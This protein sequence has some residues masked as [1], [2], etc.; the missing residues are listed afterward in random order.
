MTQL[1]SYENKQF[2]SINP[3]IRT[4][5]T[6][7]A[8]NSD[9]KY[10]THQSF[11]TSDPTKYKPTSYYTSYAESRPNIDYSNYLYSE[12]VNLK[13]EPNFNSYENYTNY[14]TP[15]KVPS[16]KIEILDDNDL[17]EKTAQLIN[18][19]HK[20]KLLK[21]QREQTQNHVAP[22]IQT[23]TTP[24]TDY[25][26]KLKH[27]QEQVENL[28]NELKQKQLE[29]EQLQ[30]Q[31]QYH[32]NQTNFY[33]SNPILESNRQNLRCQQEEIR[34]DLEQKINQIN[35]HQQQ[36]QQK[37]IVA[38][39]QVFFPRSISYE[40]NK[41]Y[42]I[43]E[44]HLT[45]TQKYRSS[46]NAPGLTKNYT[47]NYEIN[48]MSRAEQFYQ[49]KDQE[50]SM[51]YQKLMDSLIKKSESRNNLKEISV[52]QPM[53][54]KIYDKIEN[55][56][57]SAKT[58]KVKDQ[59]H[60]FLYPSK[61]EKSLEL[62][63][64]DDRNYMFEK[65]LREIQMKRR[66]EDEKL[67]EARREQELR[68]KEILEQKLREKEQVEIELREQQLKEKIRREQE[69][70]EKE[71]LE[72][73]LREKEIIE[74][75]LIEQRVKEKI[76]LEQEA[77][78]R[79]ILEKKLKEQELK[80]KELSEAQ[81]RE[82]EILERQLREKELIEKELRENQLREHEEKEILAK[83]LR[84][85]EL[86][87]QRKKEAQKL[88]EKLKKEKKMQK[89]KS[90]EN[91][92]QINIEDFKRLQFA[93]EEINENGIFFDVHK[94]R[95]D[96]DVPHL[97]EDEIEIKD[98]NDRLPKTYSNEFNVRRKY[99]NL[100]EEEYAQSDKTE[101]GYN[102]K[103]DDLDENFESLVQE[104]KSNGNGSIS[105]RLSSLVSSNVEVILEEEE[106]EAEREYREM[107][108][109]SKSNTFNNFGHTRTKVI[110]NGYSSEGHE[111]YDD[112]DDVS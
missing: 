37:P 91:K 10:F 79:E 18:K 15:K 14:N 11:Y 3:P 30:K 89:F 74:K 26:D 71:L 102:N 31:I 28:Q 35:K 33:S 51:E 29:Q 66:L 23:T 64:N 78:E 7:S 36:Q 22:I 32:L 67:M 16:P 20:L 19:Q 61:T 95:F 56:T 103:N 44:K 107:M 62:R 45:P 25:I 59:R 68:E 81:K 76:R 49:T 75:Q 2:S 92:I 47:S 84:D 4:F 108:A 42:T 110:Q 5:A 54:N 38:Q 17:I 72:Q 104:I 87:E 48:R 109:Y 8:I 9:N 40:K 106:E 55:M 65:H 77:R 105:Q 60:N 97:D 112:E 12:N 88:K 83:K 96:S 101:N 63:V 46:S 58:N 13:Q 90:L 57:Y 34:Q 52:E 6:T 73:K 41:S 69:Q 50:I 98:F 80:A 70:R 100:Y 53:I 111:D 93:E 39:Q 21:I 24:P 86:C 1:L 99:V 27:L 94:K 82:Q 85:K 43:L